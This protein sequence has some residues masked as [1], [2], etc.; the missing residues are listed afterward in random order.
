MEFNQ[1]LNKSTK[2]IRELLNTHLCAIMV[3]TL[4]WLLRNVIKFNIAACKHA[5]LRSTQGRDS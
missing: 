3:K 1:F 4:M 2:G 5:F